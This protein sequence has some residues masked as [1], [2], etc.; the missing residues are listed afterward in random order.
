MKN[1]KQKGR[2]QHMNVTC[3]NDMTLVTF[4]VFSPSWTMQNIEYP[5]VWL[6]EGNVQNVLY[7]KIMHQL[8]LAMN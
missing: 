8:R 1:A 5:C 2:K 3:Q 4:S 7:N 6:L